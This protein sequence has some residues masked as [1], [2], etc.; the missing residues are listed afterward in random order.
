M[1]HPYVYDIVLFGRS[2]GSLSPLRFC[3]SSGCAGEKASYTTREGI[4]YKHISMCFPRQ[5]KIPWNTRPPFGSLQLHSLQTLQP[6]CKPHLLHLHLPWDGQERCQRSSS[7]TLTTILMS[8]TMSKS[9]SLAAFLARASMSIWGFW[10]QRFRTLSI[11]LN[12]TLFSFVIWS[13]ELWFIWIWI[14]VLCVGI[15]T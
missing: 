8:A 4:P 13:N 3:F 5:C 7:S 9:S 14:C 1:P 11:H 2:E 10:L 12:H 6:Q 15:G